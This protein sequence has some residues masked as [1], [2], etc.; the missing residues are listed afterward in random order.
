MWKQAGMA[1]AL[2]AALVGTKLSHADVTAARLYPL[3]LPEPKEMRVKG[4]A[5]WAL[6]SRAGEL[7]VLVVNPS[8]SKAVIAA[9]EINKQ[10][11]RLGFKGLAVVDETGADAEQGK[12]LI[13]IGGP[14]ENAVT[15]RLFRDERIRRRNT[16]K[17]GQG[18]TI[19][20]VTS[21]QGRRCVV[22][23]GHDEQ[24]TLYG[25]VT[26]YQMLDRE[27]DAL[28]VR[29]V[30]VKD[31]PDFKNRCCAYYNI[32]AR[33]AG[34]L[35]DNK[36]DAKRYMDWLLKHKINMYRTSTKY[37][38]GPVLD[39]AI[40]YG[41]ARGI[42]A[43]LSYFGV[44][45]PLNAVGKV[46]EHK[47]DPEFKK[48]V[49]LTPRH[50]EFYVSYTRD[51]L[52]RRRAE[53]D[54]RATA[55]SGA[56]AIYY[57]VIDTGSGE[58]RVR[59]EATKKR[60]GDNRAAADAHVIN[61]IC[62]A[63]K[64]IA[65]GT[66]L[67]FSLQPYH[68]YVL[69]E[70]HYK[71]RD[72]VDVYAKFYIHKVKKYYAGICK[73]TPADIFITV[74]EGQKVWMDR[75]FEVVRRPAHC[76]VIL[77]Q[78][79]L[80]RTRARYLKTYLRKDRESLMDV[81]GYQSSFDEIVPQ[82]LL[83]Q[84]Y[85][86]NAERQ[87]AGDW[88]KYYQDF[89]KDSAE[90]REIVQGL[91]PR[92]CDNI[93][94]RGGGKHFV[95][96]FKGRVFPGYA[97]RPDLFRRAR[98]FRSRGFLKDGAS[99]RDAYN[100]ENGDMFFGAK[101]V[102]TMRKQ[103]VALAGAKRDVGKWLTGF[104][105]KD[106]DRY[107]YAYG[108]YLYKMVVLWRVY[109]EI[110]HNYMAAE[111]AIKRGDKTAAGGYIEQ[112]LNAVAKAPAEIDAALRL[113]RGRPQFYRDYPALRKYRRG[114]KTLTGVWGWTGYLITFE[115]FAKKLEDLRKRMGR[116]AD[117]YRLDERTA[118]R[119]QRQRVIARRAKIAPIL[120]GAP[121]DKEWRR[122]AWIRKFVVFDPTESRLRYPM[123]QTECAALYDT[124]RLYVGLVVHREMSSGLGRKDKAAGK[125]SW[126]E[127]FIEPTEKLYYHFMVGPEG[128]RYTANWARGHK[129]A[130]G[131]KGTKW[132]SSWIA[133]T[134][135]SRDRWT[136]EL[137]IPFQDLGARPEKGAVWKIN[138]ARQRT[139]AG[140]EPAEWSA[141]Q[142]VKAGFH[143][144]AR[145][146]RLVFEE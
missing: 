140:N 105:A 4:D 137:S 1:L 136:A 95:G 15:K 67:I 87:G 114:G 48:G 16:I 49:R 62:D 34:R 96:L 31:W 98:A 127:V 109:A 8:A 81:Y 121:D 5:K 59:S 86:W 47:D 80:T 56:G 53:Y 146:S 44:T 58:W 108:T 122:A 124:E 89:V 144:T 91:L 28:K 9:E 110:W 75:W 135:L 27:K 65:P 107:S 145:F 138:I 32:V 51:D 45:G 2:I 26:F 77:G 18:Y 24:G 30:F 42:C 21:A 69:M 85:L 12:I 139:R 38:T 54:A 143:D 10:V 61:I 43:F 70:S 25:A 23:S 17:E 134:Q 125:K 20:F 92:I 72:I 88:P 74:R 36:E 13:V 133:K 104:R 82:Q 14:R 112:G 100:T 35:L 68:A 103:V 119:F 79:G 7:A 118:R 40:R 33:R 64:R 116:Q 71:A 19:D 93:W 126:V 129:L 130:N 11:R 60:F 83:A 99:L 41:R 78:W 128:Y 50:R 3:L 131:A 39:A 22:I 37:M 94:G 132:R 117:T 106:R 90:P 55:R 113:T 115:R 46:S 57:H 63:Y 97:L 6:V 111:E 84:E 76:Y 142:V 29:Q 141:I 101:G 66:K 52:L 73:G 120:D 102:A 123:E